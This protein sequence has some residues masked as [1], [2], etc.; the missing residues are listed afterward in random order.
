[1]IDFALG[2]IQFLTPLHYLSMLMAILNGYFKCK[3]GV[4]KGDPLSPILFY[5]AKDVLSRNIT[6]LVEQGKHDLIKGTR[7]IQVPS[8]SLYAGDVMLFCKG[9]ISSINALI[10]L[11]NLYALAYG[12]LISIHPN[13]L[14]SMDP[15]QLQGLIISLTL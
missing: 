10:H 2:A 4:R 1:M 14:S 11:F 5:I 13:Q 8:Y 6:K 12:Q 3:R 15:F 7:S 9:E